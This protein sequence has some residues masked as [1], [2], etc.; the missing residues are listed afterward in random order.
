MGR[1][2]DAEADERDAQRDAQR[3]AA[4]QR[5]PA[6][7]ADAEGR[8]PLLPLASNQR[9]ARLFGRIDP[10]AELVAYAEAW[11]R[12]IQLHPTP[13]MVAEAA[14]Q[15][16]T[17]PLVTVALRADGSVES[18]RFVLASGSP[19]VD[20]MIR[21]ILRE[22]APHPP[23]PPSLAASFD[24]IEIRRTWVFDTAVRLQ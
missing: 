12:R 8:P 13:A 9:R 24:V 19:A 11:A 22:L 23:F 2:L 20:E 6:A 5:A 21:R 1:Q 16:H 7:P 10:N 15:R 18:V 17:A 3:D 14:A 4:R